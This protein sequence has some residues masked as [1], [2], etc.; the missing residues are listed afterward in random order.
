M[1]PRNGK[2]LFVELY[3]MQHALAYPVD[4]DPQRPL[5]PEGVL[6]AKTSA[7]GLR[8]LGLEFDLIVTSPRRRAQQTAALVA[9]ATRFPYSDI[10][11]TESVLPDQLPQKLFD[12]LKTERG[13]ARV[14]VVGHLPHLALVAAGL[15]RGGELEIEHAGLAG[16]QWKE[17]AP[18]RLS[19]LLTARQLALIT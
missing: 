9:E 5:T 10:L 14:L 8:R 13:E 1:T 19:C 15:L 12:L 6:Q 7:K 17:G 3:L 4:E 18:A 16:F 2:G 11:T